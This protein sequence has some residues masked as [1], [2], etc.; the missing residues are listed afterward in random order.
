MTRGGEPAADGTRVFAVTELGTSTERLR[1]RHRRSRRATAR[2]SR[3][4]RSTGARRCCRPTATARTTGSS[5]PRGSPSRSRATLRSRTPP[6]PASSRVRRRRHRPV[7][8][9]PRATIAGNAVPDGAYTWTLRATDPWGNA[10]TSATGSF[11]IDA[12]APE[13]R[14][15][16][17]MRRPAPTAGSS[18]RSTWRS[19]A[20]DALSGVRSISW[21]LDGGAVER[22]RR[23][24]H[25]RRATA[26]TTF[27]YRATRQGRASARPG[28]P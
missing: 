7:R 6:A 28:S 12:T 10:G 19:A 17:R 4:G 8:L 22:L 14:P 13:S 20:T 15:R 2:T 16:A 26:R 21:R 23:R 5:S 11:T 1:P 25:G 18:R 27:E 3:P 9:G 24:R